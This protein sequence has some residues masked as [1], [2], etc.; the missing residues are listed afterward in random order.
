MRVTMLSDTEPRPRRVAV[1]EACGAWVALA[2]MADATEIMSGHNG[3]ENVCAK[4]D[5]L[6]RP[7]KALAHARQFS[8][9][10]HPIDYEEEVDV[11]RDGL[12]GHQGT[13]E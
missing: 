9:I 13:Q 10:H 6:G 4:V 11:F 3:E 5:G 2:T 8:Q 7:Y 12:T 1:G